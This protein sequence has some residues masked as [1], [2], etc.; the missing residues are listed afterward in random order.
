MFIPIIIALSL[1]PAIVAWLCIK[2]EEENA[3]LGAAS[4]YAHADFSAAD[5]GVDVLQI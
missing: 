5:S 2:I 3:K 1:V 4:K